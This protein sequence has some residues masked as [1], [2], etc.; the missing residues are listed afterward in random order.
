MR[1]DLNEV[2][3]AHGVPTGEIYRAPEMLR[4]PHF[5][6][7]E[8]IVRLAHPDFGELPMQNVVPKLSDTPGEV[9]W[10]GPDLGAHNE[11][12]L[13]GLLGLGAAEL[14]ELVTDDIV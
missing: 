11:E 14:A 3:L 8:A 9:R 13:S 1:E 5:A 10:V 7:R 6:A 12:I 4:D 2:L